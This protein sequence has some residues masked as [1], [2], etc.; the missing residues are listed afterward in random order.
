MMGKIWRWLTTQET[1]SVASN[2]AS[3]RVAIDNARRL[4]DRA[5]RL[6]VHMRLPD[7]A[8]LTIITGKEHLLM[9]PALEQLLERIEALEANAEGRS[10]K[11]WPGGRDGH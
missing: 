4:R 5:R 10:V 1:G 6:C 9:T 3:Q 2:E 11:A 7:L 8:E